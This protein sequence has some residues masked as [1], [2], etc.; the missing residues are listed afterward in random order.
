MWS[1]VL[2]ESNVGVAP[3]KDD[4]PCEY[5]KMLPCFQPVMLPLLNIRL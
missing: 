3:E 4:H 2:Y 1:L 5:L